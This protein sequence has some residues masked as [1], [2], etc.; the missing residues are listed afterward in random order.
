M[1]PTQTGRADEAGRHVGA[2]PRRRAPPAPP[3]SGRP[4]QRD[5]AARSVAAASLDP[6]PIPDAA[7]RRLSRCSAARRRRCRGARRAAGRRAAPDCRRR[8]RRAPPPPGRSTVSDRRVG[9]RGG[10][11]VADIG[12]GDQAVEQVIAVGAPP[13][14]MQVEV[15]LR[16]RER[17]PHHRSPT[18]VRP[19][20]PP[21]APAQPPS[22]AA[23]RRRSRPCSSL[24]SIG[25][26]S[27]SCGP[28]CSAR[29][30]W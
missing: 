19:A 10:H 23:R 3:S 1:P 30:H 4:P 20:Q 8:A 12:E 7:G 21:L 17:R 22:R 5:R 25:L 18:G 28:N 27:S 24:A 13:G 15:D 16:R 14:D 29:R 11:P 26:I 2:E 6:P 9:R